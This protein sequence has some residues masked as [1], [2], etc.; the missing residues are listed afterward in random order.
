[1]EKSLK[2]KFAF[3]LFI[4]LGGLYMVVPTLWSLYHPDAEK[5]P[6]YLPNTAMRLGLDL[7]GGIH[8]VMGVDLDKVVRDQ[9]QSYANSFQKALDEK[10]I[11]G[12]K[13]NFNP[14]TGD[15]EVEVSSPEMAK[16]VADLI[17]NEWTVLNLLSDAPPKVTA[18]I[19]R[20]Q[21]LYIRNNA[22]EQSIET[23]RNRIDEFGVAEPTLAKKGDSQILVQFPGAKEPDRL[24]NLI[25]QTAQL[26]FQIVHDCRD[27]KSDPGCLAQ[28]RAELMGKISGAEAKGNYSRETFNKFSEYRDRLNA[29][30]A[31]ELP[32]KTQIAFEKV[33]DP[34]QIGK[35]EWIPYL[36]STEHVVSGEYIEN[37]GVIMQSPDQFSPPQPTVSFSFDAAGAPLFAKLTTDFAG[38]YMAIVLDG[39]VKSAPIINEP[40]TG[41]SG[42]INVGGFSYDQIEKEA[43]DTAIV[44][45]AGALPASIETQEERVIGPSIGL[46]AIAAGKKALI[47]AS[48]IIFTFLILYYGMAGVIGN[49]ATFVNVAL[50]F[51]VLGSVG[52][53]LTLPGIAGIV[54]T[55]G[56]A[57]DSM[58]LI[59]ER[60]REETRAGRNPGQVLALGF[61]KALSSILDGNITT[62][63]GG[64]VLLNY[65]T[66]SI[67]GF[68]LTLLVGIIANLFVSTFFMKTLFEVFSGGGKRNIGLG[69]GRDEVT[70]S[71]NPQPLK[72]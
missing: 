29:D 40:I 52:A 25:G 28:K 58:I 1:M 22:L 47:L 64:F 9:S 5:L 62:A 66:G 69:I 71:K 32:A 63:I 11:N 21:E 37:A 10:K 38:A 12:A 70:S 65:G 68:A 60:M 48:I 17:A 2:F 19:A 53:T 4:A 57:V 59:F 72:V 20:D 8:M 45:R 61:D 31:A 35:F 42:I 13:S 39:I 26:S 51:A 6:S 16:Q 56:M 67:R 43:R 23:L 7:K 46:D 41:G 33:A 44:L 24:K 15:I 30:L 36:L 49:I 18:H 14:Q 27:G 55:L 3:C 34:Q 54:L 50:I